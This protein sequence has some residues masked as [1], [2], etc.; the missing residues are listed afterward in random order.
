M[1][2]FN[3]D[4]IRDMIT[5]S[6]IFDLLQECGGDPIYTSFGIISATICH[7]KPGDGSRKLYFYEN[8]GLFRCYTGCEE[9]NFDI[10]ELNEVLFTFGLPVLSN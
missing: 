5:L 2:A 9:P 6:D 10:F 3:K 4:T 7:N 1:L 8:S